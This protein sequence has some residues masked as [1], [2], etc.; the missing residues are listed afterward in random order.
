MTNTSFNSKQKEEFA[1]R[2]GEL[3][4]S[5]KKLSTPKFFP[6]INIMTGP[7]GIFRTGGI[8]RG[9][10][11]ELIKEAKIDAFM[12]QI[13]HF[14]DYNFSKKTLDNW[15]ETPLNIRM[16]DEAGYEPIIFADSGGFKL[17]FTEGIDTTRFGFSAAPKSI[18]DLQL[19]LGA[20][21][22]ATLDYP[23]P[24]NLSDSEIRDR[25][26]KSIR[27]AI[28]T[29][30][31]IKNKELTNEKFIYI[32]VHG[33]DFSSAYNYV[34]KT[35]Q[36]IKKN[37]LTDINFG[38]AIGSLVPLSSSN[39]KM[40]DIVAGII[41]GVRS[42]P[43][44]NWN[45]IPIHAFGVSGFMMP[46]LAVMGVDSFDSSGFAQ[47]A[48]NLNYMKRFGSST[49]NFYDLKEE[50]IQCNCI[51]CQN[52]KNNSLKKTQDIMRGKSYIT[53][54]FNGQPIKKYK[55]YSWIAC[56]NYRL[57]EDAISDLRK[58]IG[59]REAIPELL[60]LYKSD[61]RMQLLL[62]YLT[63]YY[64]NLADSLL[65][66]NL[67]RL[68][69]KKTSFSGVTWKK[70]EQIAN[71]K[72][73]TE[74]QNGEK[75]SLLNTPEN[76]NILER[77][78]KPHGKKI[79]LFTSCSK[80]KPYSS[81]KT[82]KVI[83]NTVKE[84]ENDIEIVVISGMYGPVPLS[85]DQEPEILGYN[86]MLSDTNEERMNLLQERLLKFID[87]YKD[88]FTHTIAYVTSKPYRV[89]V[90]RVSEQCNNVDVYPKN[91]KKRSGR[92]FTKIEN[93]MQLKE[94]LQQELGG[95]S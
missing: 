47:S 58:S 53:H 49:T 70:T 34:T 25:K 64:D 6:I 85:E 38:L 80:N 37:K 10:K 11:N 87:E 1:G 52:F 3:L 14:L 40:V 69:G 13:L 9:I 90:E 62:G 92:E 81:S 63:K 36:E 17:L 39:K 95:G 19:R 59:R 26:Q 23:I 21:L 82:I 33:Y 24:P 30:K 42:D 75:I 5:N 73:Q 54:F 46:I 84:W 12:T 45:K 7:P 56:H 32:P 43:S 2:S 28:E 31:L 94:Y 67:F 29:L 77:P 79:L 4:I 18:L 35:L 22:L 60:H 57:I 27:N 71:I 44:F 88:S 83:K 8:W 89:L 16:R 55:I 51:Y 72:R 93:L 15:L 86:Y 50:D 61:R 78:Y 65:E 41:K 74:M 91:L 68:A 66:F 48:N 76:Y 20:D